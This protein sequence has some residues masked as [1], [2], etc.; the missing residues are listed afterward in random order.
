LSEL[1]IV[2]GDEQSLVITGIRAAL[3]GGRDLEVVGEVTSEEDLR[4]LLTRV[5]PDVLLLD[6]KLAAESGTLV[7]WLKMRYPSLTI[8]G[9][10]DRYEK[11]ALLNAVYTGVTTCILKT[12]EGSDL[13]ALVR[14][15]AR[16]SIFSL[17]TLR[18]RDMVASCDD[19]LLSGREREV[20]EK[21]AEGYSNRS[22]ARDLWLSD[23]TVK[24][25]LRNIYRKLGVS[26]RTEAAVYVHQNGLTVTA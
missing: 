24:F 5:V 7:D 10:L 14:Q 16:K 23:Q 20:L 11:K 25:H 9:L 8:I 12:V 3:A 15:S 17:G 18:L 26:N 2:V 21:V 13:P 22:I 6:I 4:E 1:T 19:A